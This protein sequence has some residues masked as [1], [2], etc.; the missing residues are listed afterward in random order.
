MK[1]L[2]VDMKYEYGMS[3]RGPNEIGLKGFSGVFSRL[4]HEVECFY[5][6]HLL[7]DLNRLN[8]ELLIKAEAFVPDIIYFNIFGEQMFPSTLLKLKEKYT[9]L[10]WFGDDQW[11]FDH[12]SSKMSEYF[13]Y[14]VTTDPFS[15]M[16]YQD[17]GRK[18]ILS[19]WAA[20]EHDFPF[21][22][23]QEY[24]YDVSFVGGSNSVRRWFVDSLRKRGINVASF[25]FGWPEG[26]ISLEK[27][28]EVFRRSKINLNLSNSI[29]Y[30]IRYLCHSWKNPIVAFRDK[31]TASQIKARNFEI[32]YF[33][34]FQMTDYVPTLEK[35]L[36]I[37]SEVICY[38]N[39]DEA[40][41]LIK[42]YLENQSE[43]EE[44]RK[45]SMIRSRQQ[46]TYFHR[47]SDVFD[48]IKLKN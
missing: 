19:Q 21:S 31:K 26:P 18:V 33:G 46:H 48:S 1:I 6:D 30:D 28:A 15:V 32:P 25:G 22:E 36:S 8:A 34:G 27:M 17:L 38:S 40:E 44:I 11:R 23:N 13:T 29:N 16:K 43:R 12:F 47:H 45:A 41:R 9:T 20:I 5:Y 37:G 4:G 2:Y 14:N 10:N 3:H 24:L 7:N 39:L 35:Y 42:F